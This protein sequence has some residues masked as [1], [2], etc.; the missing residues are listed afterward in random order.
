MA[1]PFPEQYRAELVNALESIDLSAV[2]D[3]IKIFREARAHSRCIFVCGDGGIAAIASRLLCDMLRSSNVNR[4]MKF[5]IFALTGELSRVK[6]ASDDLVHDHSLVNELRNVASP[7]DVVVGIA[8]SGNSRSMLH[9]LE[10]A[11]EIGCRTIC[12]CGWA[13]GKLAG[14]S[15]KAIL[16]PASHGGNVEDA[17]MIVCRMI[18]RYFVDFEHD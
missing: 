1:M 16:V 9:V 3:T 18:G 14:I 7:A 2:G 17:H 12:I 4:T 8:V 5:R 10:Y 11:N 6:A 13:G 15:E